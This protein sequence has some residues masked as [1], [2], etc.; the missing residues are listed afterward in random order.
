VR[1]MEG[2]NNPTLS[3]GNKKR[4]HERFFMGG[5]ESDSR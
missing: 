4:S 3:L 1:P 5:G 2:P